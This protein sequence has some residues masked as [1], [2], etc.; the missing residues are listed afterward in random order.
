MGAAGAIC[1]SAHVC[2]ARFVEM[3]ECGLAG[4]VDEGRA[5][6]EALLPV[7]QR[8]LRRAQPGGVQGRPARAGPDPDARRA[9]AAGQRLR[10]VRRRR[11]SP[12]IERGF[13]TLSKRAAWV[14]LAAAG[15]TFFV[16]ITRIRNIV[17]AGRALD[18]LQGRARVL[19][20]ISIAFGAAITVIALT[21]ACSTGA[22]RDPGRNA[23]TFRLRDRC[24]SE[25][26]RW[27]NRD[28][29]AP[30][31]EGGRMGVD[32]KAYERRWWILGA[33]CFS[34]FIIV[35][36]NSILNVARAD[37]G[38]PGEPGRARRLEQP[39]PVDGRLVHAGVRRPPAHRGQPG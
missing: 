26:R 34:L 8:L 22:T 24:V 25:A 36:D 10:P 19:A 17:G 37:P 32:E 23:V 27:Y 31:R 14:L 16:W 35:L 4:K 2:T 18:R 38:P 28:R 15:W 9:H 3:I 30:Y 33:L 6:A 1:A 7:V 21:A 13:V 20:L 11:P 39:A 5:H 29:S 12:L